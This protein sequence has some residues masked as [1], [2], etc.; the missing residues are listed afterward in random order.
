MD[1]P[2]GLL[3][4]GR[5]KHDLLPRQQAGP[6]LEAGK[7]FVKRFG[8]SKLAPGVRRLMAD[9]AIRLGQEGIDEMRCLPRH[10]V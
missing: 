10:R 6:V 4:P 1:V 2:A 3:D 5:Q 8:D 7:D 9:C